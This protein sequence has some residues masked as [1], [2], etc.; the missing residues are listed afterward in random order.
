MLNQLVLRKWCVTFHLTLTFILASGG[1]FAVSDDE[2]SPTRFRAVVRLAL[3]DE[4][5]ANSAAAKQEAAAT[6]CDLYVALRSDHRYHKLPMLQADCSKIRTRLLKI[7]QS[8]SRRL[9]RENIGRPEGLDDRVRL[10]IDQ[11]VQTEGDSSF[12]SSGSV[13]ASTGQ[14]DVGLPVGL[15]GPGFDTGWQLVELIQQIVHPEY[16][17]RGGGSGTI[18][19][20]SMRRVLVVSA[21]TDVHEQV[22]D[23]LKALR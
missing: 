7:S 6:L 17:D 18:R 4:A 23:L 8:E 15:A 9:K 1:S 12:G 11:A 19:Y 21:T 13:E 14:T 10:A 22:A 3:K 2:V 5:C 16:W 20:Y